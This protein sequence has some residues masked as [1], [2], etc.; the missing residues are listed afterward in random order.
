MGER[1]PT[2]LGAGGVQAG[3]PGNSVPAAGPP[4]LWPWQTRHST[5]PPLAAWEGFM[6][7]EQEMRTCCWWQRREAGPDQGTRHFGAVSVPV[8][9]QPGL[10]RF[11]L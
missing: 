2:P 6:P 9:K 7:A 1:G 4:T 8:S 10:Q 11:L 3:V 5:Q